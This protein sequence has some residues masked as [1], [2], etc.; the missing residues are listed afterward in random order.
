MIP[1]I[2]S[3]NPLDNFPYPQIPDGFPWWFDDSEED[4][5]FD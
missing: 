5:D 4:E 1:S 3:N 2:F